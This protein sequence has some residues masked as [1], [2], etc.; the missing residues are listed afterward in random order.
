MHYIVIDN[1]KYEIKSEDKLPVVLSG[2]KA[3]VKGIIIDDKFYL[4]NYINAHPEIN[5]QSD[6]AM[7]KT[8]MKA[9]KQ[10]GFFSSDWIYILAP[11]MIIIAYLAYL[12]ANRIKSK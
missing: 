7:P 5:L 8:E 4:E 2:S 9:K 10:K 1:K 11:T 3:K 6:S 12:E